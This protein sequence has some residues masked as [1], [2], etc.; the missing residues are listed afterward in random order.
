VSLTTLGL[1]LVIL[2]CRD[3]TGPLPFGRRT[4][5]FPAGPVVVSPADMHGWAFIDEPA[6]QYDSPLIVEEPAPF[7]GCVHHIACMVSGP[8]VPPS[9][10]GSAQLTTSGGTDGKALTVQAYAGTRLD[11]ITELRYSTYRQSGDS[12][13]HFAISLQLD[14]DYDLNDQQTPWPQGRLVFQPVQATSGAWQSWD[15]KAGL[16]WGTVA[17]VFKG[18]V[19]VT[20]PCVQASPCTWAQFLAAFPNIGVANAGVGAATGAVVLKAGA[21]WM[22]FIGN[23]DALAIGV[24]GTTTTFDFEPQSAPTVPVLPPDS[25]PADLA[26]STKWVSGEPH[27]AGTILRDILVLV[28]RPGTTQAARQSA[29]DLVNGTV[30]GGHP[31]PG[32]EGV[33]LVRV[34]TNGTIEPLFQAIAVLKSLPQVSIAMPDEIIISA[35]TYR[36]PI[37]GVGEKKADWRLNPDSAFG[38]EYCETTH[39]DIFA[40]GGMT[41]VLF[42][43]ADS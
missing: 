42:D 22:S 32:G 20:N 5:L 18:G 23:V 2:A 14:V 41:L 34:P 35:P 38:N 37:D 24:N 10:S 6:P 43:N 31:V 11:A 33:Y 36:R 4:A 29:I 15:A 19:K 39:V 16:W 40:A 8:G 26:D 30:V 12:G 27:Y 13:S 21:G 17:D 25:V 7:D 1:A 28:F 9:G 3:I